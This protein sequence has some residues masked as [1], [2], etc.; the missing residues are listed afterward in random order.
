MSSYQEKEKKKHWQS[1]EIF[2]YLKITE[3]AKLQKKL[4]GNLQKL[5]K[6]QND[7]SPYP[8]PSLY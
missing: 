4:L 7:L 5:Q 6:I 8:K 3:Y 2:R 1:Q